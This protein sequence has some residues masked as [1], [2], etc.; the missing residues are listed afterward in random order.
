M[1]KFIVLSLAGLLILAFGS[2]YAQEKAPVLDFKASGYIR[3]TSEWFRW[4]SSSSSAQAG[5][6]G[7]VP[8]A[9]KPGGNAWDKTAAYMETRGRL[10]FD[11]IMGK[12]LSGTIFFE[13]DSAN[14]GDT[15]GATGF[16]NR[17]SSLTVSER[18]SLGFWTADR[19]AV[20]IKNLYLTFDVPAVPVPISLRLGLQSYGFRPM[21]H[22]GSDGPGITGTIKLDPVTIQPVWYKAV[23]GYQYNADDVD[24]YGLNIMAKVNTFTIGGYGIYWNMDTYPFFASTNATLTFA[25]TTFPVEAASANQ[26]GILIQGTQQ[27]DAWWLGF[28]ADGKVPPVDIN[29]DFCYSGAT[30]K[31]KLTPT[32][33]DVK[34]SGFATR[35]KVDYPWEKFNFG[36]VLTYASGADARKASKTGYA[37]DTAAAA[38]TPIS[39]VS[40]YVGLPGGEAGGFYEGEVLFGS[41]VNDGMTGIGYSCNPYSLGRMSI[42]GLWLAKLY[43][44]AKATPWY[45]VTL[46]GLYIGDTTKHGNTFGTAREGALGTYDLRDDKTI[47]WE[48]DLVNE[49]QIYKNLIYYVSGGF[50]KPGKALE[51][52]DSTT[53]DNV[54]PKTPFIV[55]TCLKYSF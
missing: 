10:K 49:F 14:W 8:T 40:A 17:A 19:A 36:T 35:L 6:F 3:A 50:L 23:E 12:E 43:A 5:I 11:A 52:Y 29:F 32:V 28:Y 45:K 22:G 4:N 24:F 34:Y 15:P 33:E 48:L 41:Y 31:S 38:N 55:T 37:G 16:T 1:K 20:E 53:L 7:V 42:G 26:L 2:A 46:Q 27:A 30:V 44:S 13:M 54:K 9:L 51:F 25:S 47:G 18:N 21:I 39:K